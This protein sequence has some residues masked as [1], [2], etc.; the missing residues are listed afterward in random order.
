MSVVVCY[1]A[2]TSEERAATV[3]QYIQEG[4]EVD[5]VWKDVVSAEEGG[6]EFIDSVAMM[7]M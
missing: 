4:E 3:L 6:V 1:L 2:F 7:G 5:A